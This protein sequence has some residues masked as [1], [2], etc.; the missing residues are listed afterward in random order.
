MLPLSA[1]TDDRVLAV[2]VL[3]P[4]TEDLCRTQESRSAQRQNQILQQVWLSSY[5]YDIIVEGGQAEGLMERIILKRIRGLSGAERL[6]EDSSWYD[7][8]MM[9]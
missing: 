7:G 9:V 3:Y 1:I 2:G 5:A 6:A 8:L 4:L